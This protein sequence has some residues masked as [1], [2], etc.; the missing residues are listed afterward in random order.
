[1]LTGRRPAGRPPYISAWPPLPPGVW[2]RPPVP[3]LPFPLEERNFRLYAFARHGLW[4]GV[5]SLGLGSGDEVLMPAYNHGSEVEALLRAGV[6]LRFYGARG[7]LAPDECEL[8]SLAGPRTR[9]LYLIHYLGFPQDAERWRRWCDE[10]QMYLLEDAAQAWL[11]TDGGR[12]VGARGD[13]AVF[14]FYKTFGV[15][16]GAALV[17]ATPPPA[18]T[19]DPGPG[20]QGVAMRHAL[21]LAQRSGA[22]SHIARN[23]PRLPRPPTDEGDD[24]FELYPTF[25]SLPWSTVPFL[26]HRLVADDAAAARRAN[27]RLLLGELRDRVPEPFAD[28]PDGASPFVLP[29]RTAAKRALLEQLDVR[30]IRAMDMWADTHA[31]IPDRFPAVAD[32][33]ATTVGLPVHQELRVAELDRIVDAVTRRTARPPRLKVERVEEL[34]ELR[35]EWDELAARARNPFATWEWVSAWWRHFGAGRQLRTLACREADGRLVAI[36]PAFESARRPLATIRFIGHD[37]GDRLGPICDPADVGRTARALADALASGRLG[38]DVL[39]G[40]HVPADV[41]WSALLGATLVRRESSPV[42]D[43]DGSG[44]EA[45]LASR[46]RNFREQVRRRERALQRD[47]RL[48]YRLCDS[49]ETLDDDLQTLFALHEARWGA[50]DEAFLPHLLP[51]HREVAALALQRGWLRL[52]ILELDARP[53]AAWEGFR[54]A[55]ADWYYQAGR[56]PAFDRQAVGFVLLAHTVRDAMEAGMQEYCLGRGGED[57]KLR[58][59]SRDP[60]L[61]KVVAGRGLAG[62]AF[63]AAATAAPAL[64]PHVRRRLANVAA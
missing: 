21:W 37:L 24:P 44:F 11:A 8:D 38:A 27:Y 16:E 13:L 28:L 14:C 63:Q 47:G 29:I 53:V 5:R 20:L 61:E 34:A 52:W 64:P 39:I 56:D 3:A 62:G 32:R 31:A 54:Y 55:G 2:L 45:W 36:V 60:G 30:G 41:G 43:I 15:A 57:Y 19:R 22:F 9:A 17:S 4:H 6:D 49:L 1:V 59:A 35:A 58:F 48:R 40:E 50:S 23:R 33:R 25:E 12:P 10:R 18:L 46:S 7:D 26:V 42:L 51:F